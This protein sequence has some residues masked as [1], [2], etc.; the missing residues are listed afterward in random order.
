[1]LKNVTKKHVFYK[2]PSEGPSSKS[3]SI[4]T[5]KSPQKF[6]YFGSKNFLFLIE[7]DISESFL[8]THRDCQTKTINKH[9]Y[10]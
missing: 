8:I 9:Y 3:F 1:M 6:I 2:K 10:S 7:L 4:L 5:K